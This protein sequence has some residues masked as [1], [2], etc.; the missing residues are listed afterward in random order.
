MS[1]IRYT[2]D[3]TDPNS[4]AVFGYDID[5]V[6]EVEATMNGS[7]PSVDVTEVWLDGLE[8]LTAKSPICN[9]IGS[10]IASKAGA[11]DYVIEAALEDAGYGWKGKGHNDPDARWVNA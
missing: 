6:L 8:L 9:A 10:V 5:F 11:S 1:I 2:A 4:P 7:E 3:I